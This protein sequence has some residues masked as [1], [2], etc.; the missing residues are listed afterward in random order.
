MKLLINFVAYLLKNVVILI[1]ESPPERYVCYASRYIPLR[2][3]HITPT[4]RQAVLNT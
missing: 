2:L 3:T 4:Y 1:L